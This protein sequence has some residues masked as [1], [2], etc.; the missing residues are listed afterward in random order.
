[1][2]LLAPLRRLR[3]LSLTDTAVT[4]AGLAI[5]PQFEHLECLLLDGTSVGD[6]ATAH[7]RQLPR[8]RSV[9]A[10]PYEHHGQRVVALAR[11]RGLRKL[12]VCQ[13]KVTDQ[14]ILQFH[15]L[16]PEVRDRLLAPLTP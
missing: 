9:V 5:L 12:T 11:L 6:V 16:A 15:V 10:R 14:G 13:T 1:M 7:L 2:V 4:D 8:P 3:C